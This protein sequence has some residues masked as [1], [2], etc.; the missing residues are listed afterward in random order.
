MDVWEMRD[1][2]RDELGVLEMDRRVHRV[3]RVLRVEKGC[4]QCPMYLQDPDHGIC[5][6]LCYGLAAEAVAYAH[7]ATHPAAGE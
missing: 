1:H 2:L 3:C 7:G 5:Q 6:K 4:K